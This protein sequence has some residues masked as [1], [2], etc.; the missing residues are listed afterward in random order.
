MTAGT[1]NACVARVTSMR[2]SSAAGATSRTR[3]V[4]APTLMPPSAQLV[5]P[6]WNSGIATMFVDDSSSS[7]AGVRAL[8]WAVMLRWVSMAPFGQPVVPE[9]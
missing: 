8:A 9:V 7:Y 6:T 4:R 5:P 1:K 2:S 3:I